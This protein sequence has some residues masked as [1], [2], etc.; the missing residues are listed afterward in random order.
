MRRFRLVRAAVLV[1][2]ALAAGMALAAPSF[3]GTSVLAISLIVTATIIVL[4]SPF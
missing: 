3:N 1:A 2:A 4:K